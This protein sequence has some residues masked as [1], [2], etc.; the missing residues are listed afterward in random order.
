MG[1]TAAGRE[2]T[3]WPASMQNQRPNDPQDE[4]ALEERAL[5][6]DECSLVLTSTGTNKISVIKLVRELTGL[7]LAESK[8][9][10]EHTPRTL[11]EGLTRAEAEALVPRFE[12]VGAVVSVRLFTE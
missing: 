9:L 5:D 1:L 12:L 7:G 6:T 8:G 10:V 4:R 2:G 11:K 3:V